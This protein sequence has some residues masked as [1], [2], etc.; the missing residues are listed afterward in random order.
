MRR[1]PIR[2]LGITRGRSGVVILLVVFVR[3]CRDFLLASTR[4]ITRASRSASA[5]SVPYNILGEKMHKTYDTPSWCRGGGR[6]RGRGQAR[7]AVVL[8]L[9]FGLQGRGWRTEG[10]HGTLALS[11]MRCAPRLGLVG[12]PELHIRSGRGWA[13]EDNRRLGSTGFEIKKIDAPDSCHVYESG[14]TT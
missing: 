4:G 7:V 2:S 9:M 14:E 6:P 11:E 8:I 5:S 1:W 13:T 12:E 3:R 10:G